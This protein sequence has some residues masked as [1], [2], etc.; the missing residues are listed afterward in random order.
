ME[1][2][3]AVLSFS[4]E[5]YSY[6]TEEFSL[7]YLGT[8]NLFN[9]VLGYSKIE[10]KFS[11]KPF[12]GS[13]AFRFLGVDLRI[14]VVDGESYSLYSETLHYLETLGLRKGQ[15]FYINIVGVD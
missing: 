10:L 4:K 13:K 8:L 9:D 14:E 15:T 11:K 12:K 3:K 2:F 7:C 1:D 5:Y 6:K